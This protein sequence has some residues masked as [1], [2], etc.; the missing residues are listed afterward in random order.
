MT[1]PKNFTRFPRWKP[2][3]RKGNLYLLVAAALAAAPGCSSEPQY[4]TVNSWVPSVGVVTTI[5]EVSPDRFAIVSEKTVED[6]A[7][8]RFIIQK[9][10]GSVDTLTLEESRAFLT[11]E[12][13]TQVASTQQVRSHSLG[14]VLW[15]GTSGYLL[16]RMMSR[17]VS[18]YVYRDDRS[19]ASGNAASG[20]VRA[21]RQMVS[22][23]RLVPGGRTGFF[24][25]F[26]GSS[27][28]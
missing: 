23:Q 15:W 27:G 1:P 7:Q 28:S 12:D 3:A 6:T 18:P 14:S 10:D 17:P 22:T 2:A 26:R 13:T 11:P 5:E 19:Y 9:L 21:S 25:N 24:R 20:S 8:S 4:E 16:G